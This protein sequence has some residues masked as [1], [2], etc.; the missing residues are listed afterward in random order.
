MH[1]RRLGGD[2]GFLPSSLVVLVERMRQSLSGVSLSSGA[3]RK[4]PSADSYR[5]TA[6]GACGC[7]GSFLFFL[8]QRRQG[9]SSL[10]RVTGT[11]MP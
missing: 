6:A 11:P 2:E 10:P 8:V 5:T 3:E 7:A 4:L 1:W 9:N